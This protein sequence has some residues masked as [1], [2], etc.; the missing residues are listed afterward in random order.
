MLHLIRAEHCTISQVTKFYHSFNSSHIPGFNTPTSDLAAWLQD[1][2]WANPKGEGYV[3]SEQFFLSD[4]NGELLGCI[5]FRPN[6]SPN[7]I[8]NFGLN[9]GYS[10]SPKYRG[11]KYS[12]V[13]L[14]LF[15][16]YAAYKGYDFLY[17]GADISNIPST[18]CIIDNGG[19]VL[20]SQDGQVAYKLP[21]LDV[22]A[23]TYAYHQVVNHYCM[24]EAALKMFHHPHLVHQY[25]VLSERL[26]ILE[27]ILERIDT[28]ENSGC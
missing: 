2:E 4:E 26:H 22:E 13:M 7:L 15:M 3:P 12:V 1:R 21:L 25:R 8:N 24:A 18:K 28:N 17:V 9:I 23:L 27:S 16:E 6:M 20:Y 5:N 19:Q 14:R 10:V 11:N